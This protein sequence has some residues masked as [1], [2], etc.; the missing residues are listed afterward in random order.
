MVVR[1]LSLLDK[2]THSIIAQI[3]GV[4]HFYFPDKKFHS[5]TTK[6][7]QHFQG[8]VPAILKFRNEPTPVYTH[9]K[10]HGTDNIQL[11]PIANLTYQGIH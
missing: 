10:I 4:L 9:E 8:S 5:F 2:V 1:I 11:T 6:S 7:E 3:S